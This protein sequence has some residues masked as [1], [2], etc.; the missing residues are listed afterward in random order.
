MENGGA[1]E[2]VARVREGVGEE[3]GVGGRGEPRACGESTR[4]PRAP[5][6]A[7]TIEICV[8]MVETH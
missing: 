3:P 4:L 8:E 5:S 7:S 1:S 2:W 6:A